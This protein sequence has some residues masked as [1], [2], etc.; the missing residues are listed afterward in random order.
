MR[1][2]KVLVL[3]LFFGICFQASAAGQS[4]DIGMV[5]SN[6]TWIGLS[7][8][9]SLSYTLVNAND[10]DVQLKV[11]DANGMPVR[12]IDAGTRNS[13]TY[14]IIW[15][16]RDNDGAR[17][18]DG[19]Y[20]LK[21]YVSGDSTPAY[22]ESRKWE[23]YV[24]KGGVVDS[25]G[26]VYVVDSFENE[27]KVIYPNN[28]VKVLRVADGSLDPRRNMA[29]DAQGNL[30]ITKYSAIEEIDPDGTSRTFGSG[31]N[32]LN[33][34]A[35]GTDGSVYV[36][37]SGN[38]IMR[39]YPDRSIKTVMSGSGQLQ[40]L[41]VDAQG[42]IYAS[43]SSG[44]FLTY[45]NGTTAQIGDRYASL[46]N[47]PEGNVYASGT[48]DDTVFSLYPDG[49]MVPRY[50][51]S[52]TS[53]KFMAARQGDLYFYDVL[54][55]AVF[56]ISADG[57]GEKLGDFSRVGDIAMD[58][59]GNIYAVDSAAGSVKEIYPD[60]TIKIRYHDVNGDA[61][62]N[63]AV[64]GQGD[65]YML[66]KGVIKKLY[67]NGTIA[68]LWQMSSQS[69]MVDGL[70][71][72]A[73][74]DVYTT[75]KWLIYVD[76]PET[77]GAVYEIY[78]N[79]SSAIRGSGFK[80]P[81][82]VH[83][84]AQGNV[85]VIDGGVRVI[86]PDDSVEKM[87]F[88]TPDLALDARGN[89]YTVD[90]TGYG[91]EV[92]SPY[93]K[94]T[95]VASGIDLV[96]DLAASPQGNVCVVD[97][98]A[99]REYT[100]AS[101]GPAV[102]EPVN[103]GVDTTPPE[104]SGYVNRSTPD[105]GWYNTSVAVRFTASDSGSGLASVSPGGIMSYEGVSQSAVGTARDNA[106]NTASVTVG[107]I[108]IDLT[109]PEIQVASP[110]GNYTLN[111]PVAASW[112]ASDALSGLNSPNQS[113]PDIAVDT[114]SVGPHTF[115]VEAW[116]NAGNHAVKT[117]AY[118]VSYRYTEVVSPGYGLINRYIRVV[119]MAFRLS[120]YNGSRI[121]TATALLYLSKI[122]DG[123]GTEFPPLINMSSSGDNKFNCPGSGGIYNYMLCTRSMSSG[124]WQLRIALDDGTSRIYRI[125]IPG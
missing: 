115:T 43:G 103:V 120:D 82:S 52:R 101:G 26:N 59:Q 31:F 113:L 58:D 55:G 77:D 44:I 13:G 6:A 100:M 27:I 119:P 62:E 49:Q 69:H 109:P 20:T 114:G 105:S 24:A 118:N 34:I 10:A 50:N 83:V 35:V 65:I 45:P 85:Y 116:D 95:S 16:G 8:S 12:V 28:T 121:S 46:Y 111:Q 66:T 36:V 117:A 61:P 93:N 78:A 91:V 56:R 54:N 122:T 92:I 38:S 57:K 73:Q 33:A 80:Y 88:T 4:T 11:Y 19:S 74:G 18:P 40:T 64:N 106:G 41:A 2:V 23:K 39:I 87:N 89:I 84:D 71:V 125:Y 63:I 3:L 68:T 25:R 112:N 110:A 60:G 124:T 123:P 14:S 7:N 107:E 67:P 30:Y 104:I 81:T 102:S 90:G 97:L 21:V 108:N 47:D 22:T 79:G 5:A 37:D 70:A 51:Y 9:V 1:T 76:S 98:H 99:I 53:L 86:R 72:D 32:D 17:V 75:D 29:V 42:N 15:D 94:T 48:S 96:S